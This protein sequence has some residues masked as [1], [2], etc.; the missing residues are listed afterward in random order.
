MELIVGLAGRMFSYSMHICL[1]NLDLPQRR[2][3]ASQLD[4]LFPE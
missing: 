3:R 1:G 2:F 4:G